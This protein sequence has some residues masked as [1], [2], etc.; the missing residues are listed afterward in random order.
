[1]M[2]LDVSPCANQDGDI[3]MSEKK[4]QT[5]NLSGIVSDVSGRMRIK[6]HPHRF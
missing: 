1:M 6:L 4:N 3:K 2:R 5:R